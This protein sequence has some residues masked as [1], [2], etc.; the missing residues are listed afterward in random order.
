[1][2][3]QCVWRKGFRFHGIISRK[4]SRSLVIFSTGFTSFS[5]IFFLNPS[6]S[7]S[8]CIPFDA[9][10]SNIYEVFL[11]NPSANVFVFGDF[12]VQCKDLL[13]YSGGT[14]RHGELWWLTWWIT[15]IINFS[16]RIPECDSHSR[17]LLNLFILYDASICSAIAFPPLENSDHFV[18]ILMLIRMVFLIFWE[19]LYGRIFLNPGF[20]SW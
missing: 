16:T 19:M 11:I 3:Y 10:S 18:A 5:A 4:L 8:V 2:V 17:A 20:H 9:V 12:N 13:T 7:P 14:D 6:P 1:M 15:E